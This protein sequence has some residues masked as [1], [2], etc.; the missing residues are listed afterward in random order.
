MYTV[1]L[2][3][4]FYEE[5]YNKNFHLKIEGFCFQME[6]LV[7]KLELVCGYSVFANIPN[8]SIEHGCLL[9]QDAMNILQ[10]S[11]IEED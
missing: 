5:R 9:T 11:S 2:R 3:F 10:S 8:E 4:P 6:S 7:F 1:K